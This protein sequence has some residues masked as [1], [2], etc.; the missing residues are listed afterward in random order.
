M[1][2]PLI[3]SRRTFGSVAA[4]AAVALTMAGAETATASQRPAATA[5]LANLSHLDFLLDEVPL[6]PV[7]GHTTYQIGERPTAR[8]P[9]T[10]ADGHPDGSYTRVG[11]G[12]LDPATGRWSQGAYNADDIART[13]V[14]YLRHWRQTG[15]AKSRDKSFDLLRELTYLQTATGPNAG[16]VVLW[17][18]ADGTLTPSASPVEL[19]DP[20]DSA[21]S[22]WLARTIWALGE[23]Y[24]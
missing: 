19:P 9:W 1:E 20:S 14:V 7:E 18:Q 12:S 2:S 17:Q 8:A 13:A 5:P 4:V 10:Y 6:T 24:A 11:G 16:N 23:G 3:F 15:D 21:E 22:Y